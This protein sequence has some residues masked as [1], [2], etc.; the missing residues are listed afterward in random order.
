MASGSVG[1]GAAALRVGYLSLRLASSM[2]HR[3]AG[4]VDESGKIRALSTCQGTGCAVLDAALSEFSGSW[5]GRMRDLVELNMT[6]ANALAQTIAF[7]EQADQTLGTDAHADTRTDT[8]TGTRTTAGG[9]TGAG[10][11]GD[12]GGAR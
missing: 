10:T 8:R 12:T 6:Q 3:L 4:Q 1:T 5:E 11:G 9:D 7:Y 2:L